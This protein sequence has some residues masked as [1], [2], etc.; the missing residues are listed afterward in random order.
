MI[1]LH[2][3]PGLWGVPSPSPFCVKLETYLKMAA[4]PYSLPKL[5][6]LRA[7]K[8]K[9]PYIVKDG[10]V[11]GDSGLI[12]DDLIK[13]HG[14]RVDGHLSLSEQAQALA[15]RR[16]LEEH[17]YWIMLWDRWLQPQSWPILKRDFFTKVPIPARWLVPLFIRSGQKK[18]VWQDLR[19]MRQKLD[20]AS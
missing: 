7:P 20:E 6:M 4:L 9:I 19:A 18:Q 15:F 11:L 8:G 10:R 2:Q 12:I 13:I 16:L 5:N 14:D 3:F 1:E 17:L